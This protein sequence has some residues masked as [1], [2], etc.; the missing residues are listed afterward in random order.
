MTIQLRDVCWKILVV[1]GVLLL[2]LLVGCVSD[3][4]VVSNLNLKDPRS[5]DPFE[6][7]D[8]LFPG[9]IRRL[10]T[11]MIYVTPRRPARVTAEDC[12][13]GGGEY[14]VFDRADYKTALNVWMPEAQKGDVEAQYYVG[15]LYER[16]AE[17]QPD[18]TKAAEWYQKAAKRENRRAAVNL[19]RLYEKGLGVG[20]NEA[21]ARKWYAKAN[22]TL[23][24]A[25][26]EGLL[27]LLPG[28][29]AQQELA[30]TRARLA[31]QIGLLEDDRQK[32]AQLKKRPVSPGPG[33]SGTDIVARHER[34]VQDREQEIKTLQARV[35]SLMEAAQRHTQVTGAQGPTIQ[36]VD[37]LLVVTRGVR[38]EEGRIPL[39]IPRGQPSRLTGRVVADGGIRTLEANGTRVSFDE[40]G[41]FVVILESL[42]GATKAVPIDILA[43]DQQGKRAERR[44]IVSYG[45]GTV[46]SAPG[47]LPA[48]RYHALVIGND[49][50]GS[51]W[52][53]LS[54]P[55]ADAKAMS[56]VLQDHYGFQVTT[57]TDATYE[58]ILKALNDYKK[59]LSN[60]D[61]LLVYYAGH[62]YLEPRIDRGYWIPVDAEWHD[63]TKW[64][65]FPKVTDL[66][67]LI[68]ARQVLV[69]ADSCFA[70]KLTRSAI[71]RMDQDL[72]EQTRESV[73]RSMTQKKIR[74]A[75]TS[76]GAKPVLDEGGGGHSVFATALLGVLAENR[77][78]LETERLFWA[79]QARVA[80]AARS[81]KFEQRPTYGPIHMAGHEEAGDFVFVPMAASA[82]IP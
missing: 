46:P 31:E 74:T 53:P 34:A 40:Q 14:V 13:M 68:P 21:E 67:E 27:T 56:K 49:H 71:A 37:P 69:V 48:G 51:Q 16:G 29:S 5:T 35:I 2:T 30:D 10:G 38:K 78:S 26:R 70:G 55:I 66:L 23:G 39:V 79:V 50:Y 44:L 4:G 60:Q 6:V 75:L 81:M 15:V 17:G 77:D 65:D 61:K 42:K 80:R 22:G 57:L 72:D 18:Y 1:P 36:I 19:G 45:E 47:L 82:K 20:K 28:E 7:V 11:Q 76:G 54:T 25:E 8:C 24:A 9:E 43:V 33:Q 12:A 64:I 41:L 52:M 32:L 3:T 59:T 73:L 63:N 62:G 58:Q